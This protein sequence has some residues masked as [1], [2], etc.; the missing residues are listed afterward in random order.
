MIALPSRRLRRTLALFAVSVNALPLHAQGAPVQGWA[1]T[2]TITSTMRGQSAPG[3]GATF[4]V[5]VWNGVAR[6]TPRPG[7]PAMRAL[8]GDAGVI[9][10]QDRDSLLTILN[11]AKR[12]ALRATLGE[13]AA[14]GGGPGG[15]Q[16]TV[17]D[18]A[19]VTRSAGAAPPL[20]GLSVRRI[21]LDQRYTMTIRVQEMQRAVQISEITTLDL[22][23]ALDARGAGFRAFALQFLRALGKPREVR[24]A[25][26]RKEGRLPRGVPVRTRTETVTIAGTDTLRTESSGSMSGLQRV[27]VDTTTFRIPTG[28]RVTEARRLLQMRGTP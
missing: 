25:L 26:E 9:L 3:S 8:L 6:I 14:M 24:T 4:D 16:L 10:A 17:S 5:A 13:L 22:S 11:P 20:E 15:M 1:F 7:Q 18:V 2:W 28:Y 23:A 27:T 12:D 21:A 19:S